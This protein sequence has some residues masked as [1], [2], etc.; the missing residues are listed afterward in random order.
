MNQLILALAVYP[1]KTSKPV[2]LSLSTELFNREIGLQESELE[3]LNMSFIEEL[4]RIKVTSSLNEEERL[5]QVL[6]IT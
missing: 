5:L 4:R 1:T 2:P 3:D 6:G